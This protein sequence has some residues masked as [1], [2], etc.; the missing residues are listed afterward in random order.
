M[1]S[2]CHK[3][4]EQNSSIASGSHLNIK[5]QRKTR[6]M[7]RHNKEVGETQALAVW[8]IVKHNLAGIS[9]VWS[10]QSYWQMKTQSERLRLGWWKARLMLTFTKRQCLSSSQIQE[11]SGCEDAACRNNPFPDLRRPHPIPVLT[12]SQLTD[13][14]W[15]LK[16]A[17]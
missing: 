14:G 17:M 13:V 3:P 5:R 15:G 1:K 12:N 10:P 7:P 9:D 6:G 11:Q 2:T 16:R 4:V 8:C